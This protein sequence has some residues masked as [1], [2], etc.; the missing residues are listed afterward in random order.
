MQLHI[1]LAAHSLVEMECL[2]CS[3]LLSK[4]EL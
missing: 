4:V 1:N 3:M 2:V